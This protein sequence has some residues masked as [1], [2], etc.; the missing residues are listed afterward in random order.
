YAAEA[1][2]QVLSRRGVVRAAGQA[3]VVYAGHLRLLLQP[4][5]HFEGVFDGALHAQAQ[6]FKALQQQKRVERADS[7]A[8]VAQALY[9]RPNGEGDVAKR[10]VFAKY[11]VENQPV[12]AV[13]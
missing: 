4:L 6:G 1:F 8:E 11:I 7:R 12:V 9:P 5:R 13:A 3:G 2:F 10:S